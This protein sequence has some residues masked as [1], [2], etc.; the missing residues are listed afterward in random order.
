MK[1]APEMRIEKTVHSLSKDTS[2]KE[3]SRYS[4]C[5]NQKC[6]SGSE[7]KLKEHQAK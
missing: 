4:T 3:I 7:G 2:K 6:V 5:N 1:G